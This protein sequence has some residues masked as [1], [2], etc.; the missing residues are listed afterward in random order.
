M[1][2]AVHVAVV[3]IPG[4]AGVGGFHP[5]MGRRQGSVVTPGGSLHLGDGP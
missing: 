3:F 2:S 1:G 4:Q 5:K